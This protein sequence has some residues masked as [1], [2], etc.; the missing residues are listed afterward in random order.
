MALN[1][2]DAARLG[3]GEGEK[4]EVTLGGETLRL[5]VILKN[6]LTEGAAGLPFG[7]SGIAAA[8]DDAYI[9]ITMAPHE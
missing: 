5:P 6:E 9:E 1:P 3:V 7:I 8:A 4:V 2:V